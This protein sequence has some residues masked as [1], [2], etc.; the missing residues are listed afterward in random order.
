[1]EGGLQ[2]AGLKP[3][4]HVPA[5]TPGQGPMVPGRF[6]LYEARYYQPRGVG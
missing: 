1:M 6:S 4:L 5:D 3:A 2:P